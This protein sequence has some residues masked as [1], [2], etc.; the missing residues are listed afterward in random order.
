MGTEPNTQDYLRKQVVLY[1]ERKRH[2]AQTESFRRSIGSNFQDAAPAKT[3]KGKTSKGEGKGKGKDGG[4]GKGKGKTGSKG[5][6]G[7]KGGKSKGKGKGGKP[8]APV[9]TGNNNKPDKPKRAPTPPPEPVAAAARGGKYNPKNKCFASSLGLCPYS[10]NP[11]LCKF[12]HEK[13]TAEERT[14]RD[15][16]IAKQRK[17]NKPIPWEVGRNLTIQNQVAPVPKGQ[18]SGNEKQG[19]KPKMCRAH[20]A[21]TC[22]N[23]EN[24]KFSHE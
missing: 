10:H 17:E 11:Q 18:G 14:F 5:K 23:G 3:G 20:K 24:C 6:D 19:Q 9:E 13:L 22:K 4:G 8:S 21:G 15:Q 1:L 7:S 16:W 2:D 12:A